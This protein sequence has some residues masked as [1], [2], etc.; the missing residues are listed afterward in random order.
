MFGNNPGR[1]VLNRF[2]GLLC[3]RR[4]L[5]KPLFRNEWF[6]Y[7]LATIA[8]AQPQRIRLYLD[9]KTLRLQLLDYSFPA[10]VSA[11]SLKMDAVFVYSPV[12]IHNGHVFQ[13]VAQREFKV[14]QIVGGRYFQGPCAEIHGD[15][16]IAY[17]FQLPAHQPG[18]ADAGQFSAPALPA[19][20]VRGGVR[21][22]GIAGGDFGVERAAL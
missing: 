22:D 6:H 16:R 1:P 2:Q 19:R 18:D 8:S 20:R 4:H 11:H 13:A 14:R 3:E 7:V 15:Y 9:Q 10:F 5:H 17:D 21:P 12:G